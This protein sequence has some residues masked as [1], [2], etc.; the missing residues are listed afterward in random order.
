MPPIFQ[1]P[2]MQYAQRRYGKSGRFRTDWPFQ[3]DALARQPLA[4]HRKWGRDGGAFCYWQAGTQSGSRRGQVGGRSVDSGIGLPE[5]MTSEQ[6]GLQC[7]MQRCVAILIARRS[8]QCIIA[9]YLFE[10]NVLNKQQFSP[11]LQG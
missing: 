9:N 3:G 8:N 11:D 4:R 6:I 10:L 1:K 5:R 2:K 7:G